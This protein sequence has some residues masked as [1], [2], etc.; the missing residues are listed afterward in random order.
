MEA[1]SLTGTDLLFAALGACLLIWC[2]LVVYSASRSDRLRQKHSMASLH[3]S[4]E[5][6][7]R[8]LHMRREA[9]RP[10]AG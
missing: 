3:D 4:L 5:S 1:Y 10:T 7:L 9:G 6:S 8:K 2:S